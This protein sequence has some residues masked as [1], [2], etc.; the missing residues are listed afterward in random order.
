MNQFQKNLVFIYRNSLCEGTTTQLVTTPKNIGYTRIGITHFNI[1][2]V[3]T[4]LH[5]IMCVVG[6]RGIGITLK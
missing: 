4:I 3:G 6:G 1:V 2:C 5:M